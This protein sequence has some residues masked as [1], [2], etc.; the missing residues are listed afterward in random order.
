M[1]VL[2]GFWGIS[3]S[4]AN[5]RPETAAA[6]D[7]YIAATEAQMDDDTRHDRFL[8][9]D[10]LPEA[11]R[12]QAYE[13]LQRGEPF[14]EELHTREGDATIPIPSGLIHH[15]AGVIFI[16]KGTLA[17]ATAVLSDYARQP[18]IYKPDV[19]KTKLLEQS[20]ARRKSMNNFTASR[21]SQ[22]S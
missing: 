12:R 15:W 14:I 2:S 16:P 9:V 4:A 17:R 3:T 19:R 6:F 20:G 22:W 10:R 21:S 13:Q 11:Q 7:R 18:E 1:C 8:I 5:L